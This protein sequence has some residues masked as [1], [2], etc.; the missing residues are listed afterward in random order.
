MSKH[1]GLGWRFFSENLR[2]TKTVGAVWP[3]GQ[4][5]SRT[6]AA[7]A[8][9]VEGPRRVLEV[10]PGVGPV[11]QELLAKIQPGDTFDVVELNP[12]FC[13][14]LRERFGPSL[15][16]HTQSILDFTPPYRYHRIVSGLPLANFPGDMVEAIYKKFLDLLEPDGEFIMFHY[17]FSREVSQL[18]PFQGKEAR[19]TMTL[20]RHL[21]QLEVRTQL[22]VQNMPPAIVTVRRRPPEGGAWVEKNVV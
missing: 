19:R 4:E 9:N 5:L 21:K 2:Q 14:I 18:L 6:M 16:L 1:K 11:T 8:V 15:Q 17:V 13:E 22:V 12:R 7:A 20:E 3:S 10:G